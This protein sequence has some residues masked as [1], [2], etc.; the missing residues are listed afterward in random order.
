MIDL[1]LLGVRLGTPPSPPEAALGK[2]PN[3]IVAGFG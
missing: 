2:L 3:L 1:R